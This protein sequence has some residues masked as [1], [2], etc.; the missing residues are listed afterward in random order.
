MQKFSTRTEAIE[1]TI[2]NPLGEYADDHDIDAIAE[3]T[4]AT[5][6]PENGNV[7]FVSTVSAEDFWV[8]AEKHAK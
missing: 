7:Y 4:I 2:T 8:I 3:E 1:A 5:I 6:T